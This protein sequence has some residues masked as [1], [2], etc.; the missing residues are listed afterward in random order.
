VSAG[1][2]QIP[3]LAEVSVDWAAVL[4]MLGVS[5]LVAVICSAIPALRIGRAHLS[6]AL[7]EGGR[8]GTAGKMQHRVRGAL[9]AAQIAIALVVLAGSGLLLRSFQRLRAVQPG[10]NP[11]NVATLWLSLPAARYKN[12]SAFTRFYA[13]LDNRIAELPGV[14]AAGLTSRLPLTNTGMNQN[15]LY[16][17]DDASYVNKIPPLQ[18]YTTT[19]GDY[20]RAMGIP[21]I[22]G[23]TFD[24][25]DAQRGGEAMISQKTAVQ[26][27]KDSTGQRALGKRF[28]SLPG[29]PLYTIVGVV[30]NTRDT[31]LAVPPSQVVYFPQSVEQ[32]SM[33]SQ[34]RRTMAV[35][36]RTTSDPAAIT[37]AIQRVVREL[38]PSLPTFDVKPMTTVFS[39]SMAK[40]SF[41]MLILGAAAAVTL[42]LGAIGLYGV[43]A[44]AVTLRTRELGVRLALGAQPRAVAAMMTKQGMALTAAGIT[45]GL[46]LFVLVARFLRS[47]LFGVAPSD[48]LTLAGASLMLI[49]IAALASWVPARRASRVDPAEALR[50]E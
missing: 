50:A 36:V 25:L 19:D 40:L 41:T 48:P 12:D 11:E 46:L 28:R 49:A 23:R 35:V 9:V 16:P 37:S 31:S 10:F 30:G 13:Q 8:S 18:V 15:P 22:A 14:R 33:Y 5:G 1:P 32:D 44:Y 6:N 42:L 7:R 20:F 21:L 17:E 26:F 38:D 47:F 43:M 4:F 27:W 45:G 29:G 24:R 39:A 3:R 34:A 2:A